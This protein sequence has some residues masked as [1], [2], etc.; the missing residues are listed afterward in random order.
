MTFHAAMIAG[1]HSGAGKTTVMFAL[2]ALAKQKGLAVQPFKGGPD[3]IDPGFH[4]EASGRRCRNLD[5]FLLS[6]EYVKQSFSR[7][8]QGADLSLVEGMM[9]LFDGKEETHSSAA[10]AKLLGIPVVLVIDGAGMAGSAAAIVLGFQKMDPEIRLA[11][12]IFNRVKHDGHFQYLKKAVESKTGVPCLGFMPPE[13]SVSLPERHLGLTTA[14]ESDAA[15]KIAAAASLIQVDWEHFVKVTESP[16]P[17][18]TQKKREASAFFRVGIA[19]DEAFSFY[20]EDNLDLLEQ[21][22][23]SLHFFSPLAD[24]KLPENLDLLYF[25][26]GFPELY[27]PRLADNS[28]MTDAVR[29]FYQDGGHVYAECGGLIYLTA[30]GL[31]P[32]KIQMMERLQHFGYHETTAA[33]DT[34]LFPAGKKLRSHEFHYSVWDE[35]GKHAPAYQIGERAEGFAAERL[36]ASYQ[37][38]HFGSDPEILEYLKKSF[39]RTKTAV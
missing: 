6:P 28:A 24:S 30:I 29:R 38:L 11:G 1:T 10:I 32:G 14:A 25:G 3:Y 16:R 13:K 26:G 23:A 17:F 8:S 39:N 9:G 12:V 5:L 35:E 33:A 2:T 36:V 7:N 34:F 27:A 37:H 15:S 19:R 31:I 4:H 18:E 22:G 21:A 20:Y